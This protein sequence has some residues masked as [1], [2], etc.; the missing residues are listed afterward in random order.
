MKVHLYM[1]S[2]RYGSFQVV[3][4]FFCAKWKVWPMAESRQ[5][6][7]VRGKERARIVN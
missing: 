6:E 5:S 1:L 3:A 4:L 2:E 7:R